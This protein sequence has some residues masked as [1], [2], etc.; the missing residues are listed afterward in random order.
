MSKAK[1]PAKHTEVTLGIASSAF[2]E[3]S[4]LGTASTG[5]AIALQKLGV[6]TGMVG[7]FNAP[8]FDTE[9]IQPEAFR[10]DTV[11]SFTD[12]SYWLRGNQ[13]LGWITHPNNVL[14]KTWQAGLEMV[15]T[16]LCPS[17]WTIDAVKRVTSKRAKVVRFGVDAEYSYAPK[18]RADKL[19]VLTVCTNADDY[20]KNIPLAMQ[21]F[22]LAFEGRDDVEMIIRSKDRVLLEKNDTR[23]S[24]DFGP[25]HKGFMAGLYRSADVLLHASSAEVFGFAPLEAMACG[26]PAIH[27][28]ATGMDAFKDLGIP[29]GH[30]AVAGFHNTGEWREPH[31]ECLVDALRHVDAE[32]TSV[33]TKAKHDAEMIGNRF[34]WTRA[35]ESVLRLL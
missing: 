30:K 21:A 31:L 6:R 13:K 14:P 12:P 25:R 8:L 5:L 34:N 35:A 1:V 33:M 32:Y 2:G 7:Q 27:T 20:R 15:D 22:Q 26:T 17:E 18:K 3:L 23:I 29:V 16:I 9:F 28:G 11:M 24:F 10:S 19:R 4:G